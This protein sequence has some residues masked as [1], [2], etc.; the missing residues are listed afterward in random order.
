[1][2]DSHDYYAMWNLITLE[3]TLEKWQKILH[4]LHWFLCFYPHAER[5]IV[6]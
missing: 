3:F 2:F 1:M 6:N 5:L 4:F